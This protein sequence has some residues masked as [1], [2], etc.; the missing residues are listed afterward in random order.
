MYIN[1]FGFMERLFGKAYL[2]KSKNV[3]LKEIFSSFFRS[4]KKRTFEL[5]SFVRGNYS[6]NMDG[7]RI[8]YNDSLFVYR[9]IRLWRRN[10]KEIP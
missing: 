6:V 3:I 10:I 4:L 7:T 5:V 2:T 9:K 8:Q 1:L